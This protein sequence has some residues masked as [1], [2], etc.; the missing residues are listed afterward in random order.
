MLLYAKQIGV[1]NRKIRGGKE[2][3]LPTLAIME[4]SSDLIYNQK[5]KSHSNWTVQDNKVAFT[6]LLLKLKGAWMYHLQTIL[7]YTQS[8]NLLVGKK[9]QSK[10]SQSS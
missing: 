2:T 9:A 4:T 1:G 6:I 10:N 5:C 8:P 7:Y 3:P